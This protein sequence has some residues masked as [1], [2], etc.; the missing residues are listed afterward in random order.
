MDRRERRVAENE[1]RKRDLNEQ[2]PESYKAHPDDATMDVVCECGREDCDT[3]LRVTKE[4]YEDVRADPTKFILVKDHFDPALDDL[5]SETDRFA[6]VAKRK[7][8]A[9][10]IVTATDPRD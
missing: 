1:V 9:E 6:V 5:L 2:I 8:P 4:E 10:E 3:F 7:G